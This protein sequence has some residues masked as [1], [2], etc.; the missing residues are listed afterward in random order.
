M[1]VVDD[2]LPTLSTMIN[3]SLESGKFA[4]AWKEAL[5]KPTLKNGAYYCYCAYVLRIFRYS[6]FLS[7]MLTNTGIFLRGLKL[8]GESRS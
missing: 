2:L 4:S 8:P 7:S 3:M 1:Q 6:D 5:V